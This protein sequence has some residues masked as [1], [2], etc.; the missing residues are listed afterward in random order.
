MSFEK[1]QYFKELTNF[2]NNGITIR[3]YFGQRWFIMKILIIIVGIYLLFSKD[4]AT[5]TIGGMLLGYILGAVSTSIRN[6]LVTRKY[7]NFQ[8]EVVDW[9]KV[10]ESVKLT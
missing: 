2:K 4:T 3:S 10:E 7:W 8:K 9:E 1:E 5:K 6:F